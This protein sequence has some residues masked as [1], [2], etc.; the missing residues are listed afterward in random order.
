[1]IGAIIDHAPWIAG[2]I[3]VT[4]LVQSLIRVGEAYLDDPDREWSRRQRARR[5]AEARRLRRLAK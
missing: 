1:M 5:R 3:L 2:G 4:L